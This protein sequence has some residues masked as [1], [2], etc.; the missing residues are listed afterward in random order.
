MPELKSTKILR[1]KAAKCSAE[2]ISYA[3]CVVSQAE[4][5]APN[6]CSAEFDKLT[7]C[8]MRK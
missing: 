6:A 1:D 2:G 4:G 5:L 7:K 3:K 8:L